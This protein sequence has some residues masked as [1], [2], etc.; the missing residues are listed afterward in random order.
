VLPLFLAADLGVSA[1]E[2]FD[3]VPRQILVSVASDHTFASL[4]ARVRPAD[5]GAADWAR[6]DRD[7]SGAVE[8][9][10]RGPLEA[11]LRRAE[12]AW[13]CLAI[14]GQIVPLSRLPARIEADGVIALQ[15]PLD[16]RVEGRLA[17]VL[18]AGPH[19]FVLHDVPRAADGVVPIRLSTGRGLTIG[20]GEGAR[21]ERRGDASQRVDIVL[22][23]ATP[24]FWGTLLRA[25]SAGE[26]LAQ[27]PETEKR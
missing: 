17:L 15:A 5:L 3:R 24:A 27:H 6:W 23:Q 25:A 13:L 18:P 4:R 21:A 26:D 22:T 19:R 9:N 7:G 11:D 10:E 8:P 16:L 20:A 1:V 14:D 12:T 2:T